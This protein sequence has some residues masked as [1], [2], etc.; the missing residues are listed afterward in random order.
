MKQLKKIIFLFRPR[1]SL[2]CERSRGFT[3]ALIMKYS[4][5]NC[6]TASGEKIKEVE[7][8]RG[9]DEEQVGMMC[10]IHTPRG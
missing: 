10:L 2:K 4:L 1:V 5:I 3:F 9:E 7:R 8:S 6:Y